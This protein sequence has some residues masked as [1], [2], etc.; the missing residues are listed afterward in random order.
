MVTVTKAELG[1]HGQ[2]P[3]QS[4]ELRYFIGLQRSRSGHVNQPIYSTEAEPCP[5]PCYPVDYITCTSSPNIK[6]PARCNC[7]V[8]ANLHPLQSG[9]QLHL[10]DGTVVQC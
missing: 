7:C 6:F 9:C 1:R 8:F 4:R 2:V 3:L 5:S 10:T